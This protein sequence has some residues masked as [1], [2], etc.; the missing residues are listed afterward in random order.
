MSSL[1][2]VF[3]GIWSLLC[4]TDTA[5]SSH[6]PD[7]PFVSLSVPRRML[8]AVTVGNLTLFAGG[9]NGKE[10]CDEV[11]IFF[12]GSLLRT[13]RLSKARGLITAVSV[14]DL[15]LFAGGQTVDGN[16]TDVVDIFNAT[17]HKWMVGKLSLARSMLAG[18][19][20]EQST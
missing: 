11:D 1:L 19:A 5:N 20:V 14:Q 6:D 13:D 10:D 16:R 2:G 7:F 4:V 18:A 3:L 15:A 17:S 8:S 12:N 9:L